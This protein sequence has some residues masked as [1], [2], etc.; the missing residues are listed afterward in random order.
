M[1]E[2]TMSSDFAPII[3]G[4]ADLP[5]ARHRSLDQLRNG[6]DYSVFGEPEPVEY[7]RDL[8]IPVDGADIATRLYRPAGNIA[9]LMLY[10]HGGGWVMGSLE[11]HDRPLRVF[12]NLTN[13]A[14]L[15]IDY[16]LSPEHAFPT[17]FDDSVTALRWARERV[18]EFAGG[19]VPVL[20]GGDSAG[21][22]LAAAVALASRDDGPA[23]A[24]QLLLY[25]ALDGRCDSGSYA[26]RG[27][28]K[29][30]TAE[31]MRWYWDQYAP[32][33]AQREDHRA[34]PTQAG[35]LG[36]APPAIV[37]AAG[38][39]PL[40]DEGLDYAAALAKADVRVTLLYYPDL[41]HGFFSFYRLAPSA[42]RAI[43]EIAA[44]VKGLIAR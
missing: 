15:S 24:G 19:D 18:A 14:I 6:W 2:Y 9:A 17:P 27:D 26:T 1:S 40:R 28:C 12:A 16:R 23:L 21:G 4:M 38:N 13:M 31:D 3:A 30:L 43:A 37:V 33:S 5:D 7:V 36:K 41:P 35:N 22:N 8:R 10:Y 25:P 20:V 32:D 34:S 39:D 42:G 44:Q 11:S 29:I